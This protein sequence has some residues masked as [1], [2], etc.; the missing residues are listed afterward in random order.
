M[1]A[2]HSELVREFCM[3]LSTGDMR[4]A[5]RYLADDVHYHNQPWAPMTGADTA[6]EFLQPFV[7]GT[8]CRLAKMNILH[9]AAEGDVVMNAREELWVRGTLEVVLPVAGLFVVA[10]EAIV[11]WVDYWDLATFKPMLDAIAA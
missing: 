1:S 5:R 3:A 7:D 9:Q 11:R 2:T 8:H 6:C 10:D 4:L